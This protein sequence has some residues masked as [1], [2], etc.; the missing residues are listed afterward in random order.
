MK[1]KC[2]YSFVQNIVLIS[3][4]KFPFMTTFYFSALGFLLKYICL[5]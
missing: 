1:N 2:G 5:I 3:Q 4:S